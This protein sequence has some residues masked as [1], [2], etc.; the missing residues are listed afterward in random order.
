MKVE[1]RKGI[2]LVFCYGFGQNGAVATCYNFTG[3]WRIL[4]NECN[5]ALIK[6]RRKDGRR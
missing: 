2:G 1:G 6:R 3:V 5:E 4:V